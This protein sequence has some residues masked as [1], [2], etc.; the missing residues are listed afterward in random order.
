MWLWEVSASVMYGF[1]CHFNNLRFK[2]SQTINDSSAAHVATS[3][4]PNEIMRCRLLK[5]LLD[6]PM[7]V[8]IR[9]GSLCRPR[10][11]WA[12]TPTYIVCCAAWETFGDQAW[13]NAQPLDHRRDVCCRQVRAGLAGCARPGRPVR[14]SC[15]W[16]PAI[17]Y[18]H[19]YYYYYCHYYYYYYYYHYY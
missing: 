5:W 19:C 13:H 17:H 2:Q 11:G 1:Y 7:S 8:S 4:V 10:S 9:C 6:H 18:Y 3:F 12:R 15:L 14:P 16:A